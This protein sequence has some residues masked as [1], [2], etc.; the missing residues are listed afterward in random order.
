ML[1]QDHVELTSQRLFT[2][3]LT[4]GRLTLGQI[5][6]RSKLPSRFVQHGLV[7]LLQQGLVH[8]HTNDDGVTFY[9][10]N[11]RYAYDLVR[12]GKQQQIMTDYFTAQ[13]GD[14][15]STLLYHGSAGAA[16][17]LDAKAADNIENGIA[18]EGRRA[19]NDSTSSGPSSPKDDTTSEEKVE[20]T[21]AIMGDNSS[22]D[23]DSACKTTG[24]DVREQSCLQLFAQ[25]MVVR[26]RDEDMMS[27]SNFFAL[28]SKTVKDQDFGGEVK[29]AK[30]TKEFD[31][32][33]KKRSLEWRDDNLATRN[34]LHAPRSTANPMKRG[35]LDDENEKQAEPG[36]AS[37]RR[38]GNVGEVLSPIKVDGN[39]KG[40]GGIDDSPLVSGPIMRIST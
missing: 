39:V 24:P 34:Q 11:P 12:A 7:V 6:Y 25:R 27:E 33:V 17:M 3:L 4:D 40:V 31:A 26:Q 1:R 15:T 5:G 18:Q 23:A 20:E 28:V 10:A 19:Q 37:K 21:D 9:E 2:V 32:A 13:A 36:Q 22:D 35:R 14:L 29:G 16:E 30:M 8:Y 38:K